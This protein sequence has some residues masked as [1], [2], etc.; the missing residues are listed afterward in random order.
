MTRPKVID[1]P[2]R[3]AYTD[4]GFDPYSLAT[5]KNSPNSIIAATQWGTHEIDMEAVKYY[6]AGSARVAMRQGD[7]VT[8][9]FGDHLG[10]T[11]VAFNDVTNAAQSQG[12]T[13]F[14]EERYSL[15]GDLPTDYKYTGQKEF[16]E[17]GLHFYNARWYDSALGRFTQA[18]SIIPQPGNPMAWDRYAYVLN[19]P[20]NQ[21]DPSGHAPCYDNSQECQ[22]YWKAYD[23][24]A[25]GIYQKSPT[26]TAHP[27]RINA[28]R[29]SPTFPYLPLHISTP[30]PPQPT[31][32]QYFFQYIAKG[33]VQNF[34]PW[35]FQVTE[36]GALFF[37]FDISY[38]ASITLTDLGNGDWSISVYEEFN[39]Q[40]IAIASMQENSFV[41]TILIINYNDNSSQRIP[42]G[43]LQGNGNHTI[44][45]TT[46]LNNAV[47]D[48]CEIQILASITNSYMGRPGSKG[49]QYKFDAQFWN[50]TLN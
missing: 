16:A 11:S 29:K 22:N 7:A 28:P 6:S 8:Y 21:K 27:I 47:F 43:N 32:T 14:G 44:I 18:D 10:S 40:D 50:R 3:I 23:E 46:Q 4:I 26:P 2:P 31:A 39:I 33:D 48:N 36:G 38:S 49:F 9:L 41:T 13:A 19:S 42:L 20:I 1:F 17:I 12:Y 45:M 35:G 15:G 5:R 30:I 24:Y 37:S 34:A 25:K